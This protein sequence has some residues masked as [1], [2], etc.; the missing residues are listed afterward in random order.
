MRIEEMEFIAIE[1]L[2]HLG[3]SAEAAQRLVNWV[4]A[5]R[6][7]VYI[8]NETDEEKVREEVIFQKSVEFWGEGVI[9]FDMKRLDMGVHTT[10]QN[11]QSGMLFDTEGRLPW[12]NLPMP[13]GETAVN[14]VNKELAGPD[15][16]YG[17][18]SEEAI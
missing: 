13:S 1:A 5:N 14:T 17:V 9:L 2:T 10:G 12:W 4:V 15:P 16:S 11:Y 6:A 8:F 18:I 7:D 3:R